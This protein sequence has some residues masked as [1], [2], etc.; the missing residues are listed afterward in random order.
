MITN[1]QSL[2]EIIQLRLQLT[3][4]ERLAI[5][6]ALEQADARVQHLMKLG[7]S[8]GPRDSE[9]DKLQLALDGEKASR[10]ALSNALQDKDRQLEDLYIN[11]QKLKI[12]SSNVT[13][14]YSPTDSTLVSLMVDNATL[15]REI[16]T[17]CNVRIDL[18][19]TNKLCKISGQQESV[20]AAIVEVQKIDSARIQIPVDTVIEEA[21]LADEHTMSGCILGDGGQQIRNLQKDFN[22]EVHTDRGT[23]NDEPEKLVIRGPASCVSKA[24]AKINEILTTYRASLDV[25]EMPDEIISLIVG[26]KGSRI[27]ALREKFP[28][29]TIDI[30]PGGSIRVHSINP[31]TRQ[32]I[33]EALDTLISSNYVYTLPIVFDMGVLMKGPRGTETRSLLTTDLGMTFDI[34]PEDGCIKLR[35]NKRHVEMGIEIIESFVNNNYFVDI[36]CSEDDFSTVF[37]QATESPLKGMETQYNVELRTSRKEGTVRIRGSQVSVTAARTALEGLLNGDLKQSSQIFSVHPQIFQYI[38]GKSG[39]TLKRLEKDASAKIDILKVR[40]LIRVRATTPSGALSARGVLLSFIDDIKTSTTIDLTPFVVRSTTTAASQTPN[41]TSELRID[42]LLESTSFL[43][44]VELARDNGSKNMQVNA[45]GLLRFI[46]CAK[47]H[48]MENLS[49]TVQLMITLPNELA[50]MVWQNGGKLVQSIRETH[51][52]TID[53]IPSP[54]ANTSTTSSATTKKDTLS[55]SL[56]PSDSSS[57]L[58]KISTLTIHGVASAAVA[59]RGDLWRVLEVT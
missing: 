37:V 27:A 9:Y 19:R 21:I 5:K 41:E 25:I 24:V 20:R 58:L 39:G 15:A 47:Q 4:N 32:A 45:K 7:S 18:S 1:P 48:L 34:L 43:Y 10:T 2:D 46:E 35:G 44:G 38:I 6:E 56:I 59:A 31:A 49:E 13:E 51:K 57:A 14:D 30:E 3:Q 26:K 52:V 36:P 17:R 22:V 8:I 40:N 50:A 55:T 11:C 12:A 29:A 54:L 53:C 16:E 42:R 28:D 33:R 23:N